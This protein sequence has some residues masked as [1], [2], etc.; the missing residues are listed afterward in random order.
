MYDFEVT[1]ESTL[2]SQSGKV[3]DTTKIKYRCF[4]CGKACFTR[5]ENVKFKKKS[6]C[7]CMSCSRRKEKSYEHRLKIKEASKGTFSKENNGFYGKHHTE[8]SKKKISDALKGK[9]A[10]SGNGF[11]GKHHTEKAKKKISEGRKKYFLNK[12]KQ[13]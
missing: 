3:I 10:G 11:F 8:E 13:K 1:D 4:Q 7:M 5:Y 2:G 6:E 12:K 9:A